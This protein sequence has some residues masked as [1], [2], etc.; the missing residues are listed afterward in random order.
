[1]WL[2]RIVCA[3]LFFLFLSCS[4]SRITEV[5]EATGGDETPSVPVTFRTDAGTDMSLYIFRKKGDLFLYRSEIDKGWTTDGRL[6]IQMDKGDYQFL[7]VKSDKQG[8]ELSPSPLQTDTPLEGVYF[9]ALPDPAYE[10]RI[11]PVNELFLPEPDAATR[12]YS[13]QGGET[14][15]YTLK[16]VVSQLIL[17]LKR[18]REDAAG[19][20]PDPYPAGENILQTIRKIE[21]TIAGAGASANIYGTQ[22]AATLSTTL[23]EANKDSLTQEGFAV[24]TGPFFFPPSSASPVE[25]SVSIYPADEAQGKTIR[26]VVNGAVK[27]NEQLCV[28]LW[29]GADTQPSE[30]WLL[31]LTV[32]TR[33][34]SEETEGDKGLWQ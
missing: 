7:C 24:F 6:T 17:M 15:A 20:V 31:G 14:V 22:G 18:G 5:E 3:P 9:K 1:M 33:P 28:V 16:R 34:I 13:I 26:K 12:V 11:L 8:I 32:D 23:S 25:V 2:E 21:V 30:D 29:I 27:K 10:G 19:Y 4:D